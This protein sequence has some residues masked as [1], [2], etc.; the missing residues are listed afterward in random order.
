MAHKVHLWGGEDALGGVGEEVVVTEDGESGAEVVLVGFGGGGED[1]DIIQVDKDEGVEVGAEDVV[2][3]ALEGGGGVGEAK[4]HDGELIVA[5]AGAEGGLGDV[6]GGHTNLV[7][8]VA[9][10][11][12]GEDGGPME[13]VKEL[14]NP[15]EGVTVLDGDG[16]EG[17]VVHTKAEGAILLLDKEDGGAKGG[18]AWFDVAT[19][20]EGGE[21]RS[22]F[23]KFGL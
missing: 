13:A 11:N 19:R 1:Q 8:A 15:W 7:V 4:R 12:L 23:G 3:E 18:G 14:V 10:V 16:V 17:A 6:F 22:E 5:I 9:E 20:D 21:L 2:H